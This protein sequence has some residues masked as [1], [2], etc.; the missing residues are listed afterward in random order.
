MAL[1]P[2]VTADRAPLAGGVRE[3]SRGVLLSSL[4]GGVTLGDTSTI[5]RSGMLPLLQISPFGMPP[6]MTVTV[7]WSVCGTAE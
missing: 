5:G 7:P 4:P 1:R 2:G 3:A 6:L